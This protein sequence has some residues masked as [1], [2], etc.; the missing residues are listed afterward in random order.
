MKT[1]VFE[2]MCVGVG[3]DLSGLCRR[4]EFGGQ[5]DLST[6]R[7]HQRLGTDSSVPEF[8]QTLGL[9]GRKIA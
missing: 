5:T 6:R 3:A 8:A 4:G 7:K 2:G 1:R 9:G